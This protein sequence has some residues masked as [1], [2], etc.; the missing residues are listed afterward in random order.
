MITNDHQYQTTQ[1]QVDKFEA[2]LTRATTSPDQT[3]H[4]LLQKAQVDALRSQLDD[5][6]AELAAYDAHRAGQSTVVELSSLADL[7]RALIKAR[8]AAGF[9]QRDLAQ[10]LGFTEKQIQQDEATFYA[11][12]RFTHITTVAEA[13]GLGFPTMLLLTTSPHAPHLSSA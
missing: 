13:L 1:E 9:S 12:A 8:V 10:R 4:P 3:L 11:N 5:L 7:P 2:A 6:R